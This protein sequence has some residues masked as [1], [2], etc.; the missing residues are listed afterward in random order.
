MPGLCFSISLRLPASFPM[1]SNKKAA[2]DGG[3]GHR[4]DLARC[5]KAL[6]VGGDQGKSKALG[7]DQKGIHFANGIAVGSFK[8]EQAFYVLRSDTEQ[9]PAKRL[10][11]GLE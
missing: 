10:P 3:K 2:R 1:A 6:F 7:F 11:D 9:Q 4:A 5:D 8:M